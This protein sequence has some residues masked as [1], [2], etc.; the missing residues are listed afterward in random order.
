MCTSILCSIFVNNVDK[1]ACKFITVS[2]MI[3]L[4]IHF[5][6]KCHS[7]YYSNLSYVCV[8]WFTFNFFI[9]LELK[10]L[11]YYNRL[12]FSRMKGTIRVNKGG[13][14][15]NS[16]LPGQNKINFRP[17]SRCNQEPIH[18]FSLFFDDNDLFVDWHLR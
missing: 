5:V 7:I 8:L 16:H 17:C 4:N 18:R 1:T 10:Q 6:T 12:I 15:E 13:V 3:F 9:Y 2:N 11:F 14:T